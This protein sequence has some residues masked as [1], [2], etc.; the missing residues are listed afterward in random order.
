[1][2]LNH[3]WQSTLFVGVVWLATL[4]LRQ[5]R[6]RVRYWLWVAAS[7]KF[8]V[9]VSVLVSIGAQAEWN[10]PPSVQPAVSFLMED[11]LMPPAGVP[12][13]LPI[14]QAPSV[15]PWLL[16]ALWCGGVALVLLS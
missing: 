12:S 10:A 13:A 14:S 2:L 6:A 15:L 8:L 11:V 7:V 5:N 4:S 9:P 3:L 16:F 1:A